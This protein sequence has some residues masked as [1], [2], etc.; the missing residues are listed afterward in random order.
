V[1]TQ[2][3]RIR[4]DGYR[5]NSER[6]ATEFVLKLLKKRLFSSPHAFLNTLNRH[7]ASLRKSS[8]YEALTRSTGALARIFEQAE[9]DYA[10]DAEQQ[11]AESEA[12]EAAAR[13]F[14]PPSTSDT[15]NLND[16]AGWAER[17]AAQLDSKADKLVKWL[18]AVVR[19]NGQWNQER[20]ITQKWLHDHLATRGFKEGD[21]LEFLYGG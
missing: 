13:A 1:L 5:D 7:R 3:A 11:E 14:R 20:V 16:L 8:R 12:L 18:E 10:D 15:Q 4:A 2:Y 21:R 19:P 17:A 6:I 9:E